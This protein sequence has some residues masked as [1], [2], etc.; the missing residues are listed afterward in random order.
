MATHYI[1]ALRQVQ[2]SG[3]YQIGGWSFGGLVAYEMAQQ[4]H[5]VGE[6]VSLLAIMDTLAPISRNRPSLWDSLKFLFTT[7]TRSLYP[8]L[9]DYWSLI[10]TA[11]SHAGD[12]PWKRFTALLKQLRVPGQWRAAAEQATMIHLLPEETRFRMLDELTLHRMLRIFSANTQATLHYTPQPYPSSVTLFSTYQH[13]KESEPTLGW[14]QLA[15]SVEVNPVP[16]N[17]LTMLKKPHVQVLAA[18]LQSYTLLR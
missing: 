7:V 13:A 17:H 12:R 3:P 18:A 8:F 2:P 9:L 1:E 16:G 10:T 5:Q 14:S 6:Q 11:N 4:L 15:A